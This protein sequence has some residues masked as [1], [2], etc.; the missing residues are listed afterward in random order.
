MVRIIDHFD[1]PEAAS[2]RETLATTIWTRLREAIL[3]GKLTPGSRISLRE[4][5]EHYDVSL[6]P[7]REALSRLSTDG[8]VIVEDLRGFRVAPVSVS[9]CR[10]LIRLR[11]ELEP[12]ALGESIRK[13]ND[14]WE[15]MV[16]AAFHRL[17]KIEK[18]EPNW[19]GIKAD[20]EQLNR[21]FHLAL[22]SA[23]EMPLLIEI[24]GKLSDLYD[25]YRRLFMV[26]QGPDRAV[27]GEHEAIFNATVA[28]DADKACRLLR[29]HIERS[30]NNVIPVVIKAEEAQK[31]RSAKT[32]GKRTAP[33]AL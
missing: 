24:C 20:W 13:G 6:S 12:L 19:N 21:N 4:L 1:A 8:L 27:I 30:S 32:R 22:I 11:M 5:S 26:R 10:E 18:K 17:R 3:D 9:N 23:S 15:G 2:K 25:R 7:L 29:H 14:E 31:S 16:A 33:S 28:R